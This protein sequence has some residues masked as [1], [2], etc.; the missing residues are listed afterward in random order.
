MTLDQAKRYRLPR[1]FRYPDHALG[2][3]MADDAEYFSLLLQMPNTYGPLR[4]ALKIL[5]AELGLA[6][7]EDPNQGA[8]N[9]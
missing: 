9:L 2:D 5:A 6:Q 3:V 1:G 8:L 4:E 7:K